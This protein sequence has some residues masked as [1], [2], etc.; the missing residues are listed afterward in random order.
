MLCL[1]WSPKFNTF[2]NVIT[3]LSPAKLILS[4]NIYFPCHYIC[5][6]LFHK[7]PQNCYP[8]QITC[9]FQSFVF[10]THAHTN[11]YSL[12]NKTAKIVAHFKWNILYN[13]Q[14]TGSNTIVLAAL[15]PSK[16][17]PYDIWEK[18][19][20]EK[21]QLSYTTGPFLFNIDFWS[22]PGPFQN[23]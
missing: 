14:I 12:P 3:Y 9:Q 7:Q 19:V 11:T 2:R 5:R 18:C 17:L 22:V 23:T 21:L 6:C 4:V 15:E 13:F 1:P 8:K 10:S 20:R 16:Y